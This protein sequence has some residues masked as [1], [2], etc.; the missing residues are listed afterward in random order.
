MA[1][2]AALYS[3]RN[4]PA[5]FYLLTFLISWGFW[6]PAVLASQRLLPFEYPVVLAGV[7][8][9]WGPGLAAIFLTALSAGRAELKSL[10]G[11]LL[12][13]RVGLPWYLFV[14]CWPAVLSLLATGIAML[15]G[16]PAPDFA[17]PPVVSQYPAP[18]EAFAYGFLPLLPM[19]FLTSLFSSALGEELGWRGFL[20][21]RLQSR[22]GALIASLGLGLV[23]AIWHLP[24]LWTPGESFDLAGAAWFTLSL[25]LNAVLYTWVF[26]NTRGSLL[27][28]VLFHTSQAVTNLFLAGVLDP[29]LMNAL[30]ALLV[31]LVVAR[32]G[33]ARLSYSDPIPAHP[34]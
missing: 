18:P 6:I 19:V 32:F 14:L 16:A 10:L 5:T 9:A 8:G 12:I 15:F 20:L 4:S 27:L 7:L 13:W 30:T 24:R 26:N 25:V 28:V 1:T 34:L 3:R 22:S 17:N 23:W 33:A 29:L 31:L 11:R 21:P 2:Q